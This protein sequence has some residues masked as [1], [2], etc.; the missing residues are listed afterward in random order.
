MRVWGL[1]PSAI[2][3]IQ[4]P[5]RFR[6]EGG[7][8]DQP[9]EDRDA[10]QRAIDNPTRLLPLAA[11][12]GVERAGYLV[13]GAVWFTPIIPGQ[14]G[15]AFF[16]SNVPRIRSRLA[17]YHDD[18]LPR[19]GGEPLSSD[20]EALLIQWCDLVK[21]R[22]DQTIAIAVKRIIGAILER[23]DPEDSLI[24]AVMATE[25]L[26]GHGGTTEVTFRVTTAMALLLEPDPAKRAAR[27]RELGKIYDVRSKVVHGAEITPAMDLVKRKKEAIEAAVQVL[28]MLFAERPHL[29]P[30]RD[31]GMRLLLGTADPSVDPVPDQDS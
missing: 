11:L 22:Y 14:R 2:L 8:F 16:A 31:R 7:D 26:F 15:N 13:P 10:L 27:R 4:S 28:R 3:T 23:V 9:H 6:V 5:V 19:S 25:N 30:Q 21:E 12:L 20:E 24:D 1:A 17:T 29:I 18:Q